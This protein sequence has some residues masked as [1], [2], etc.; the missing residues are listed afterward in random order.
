MVWRN[1]VTNIFHLAISESALEH[2]LLEVREESSVFG[3]PQQNGPP[4][5]ADN[6]LWVE[7]SEVAKFE[8]FANNVDRFLTWGAAFTSFAQK[9]TNRSVANAAYLVTVLVL[10]TDVVKQPKHFEK[11]AKYVM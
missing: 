11:I 3:P 5:I 2:L 8:T 10:K 4:C 9:T 6:A 1:G 7:G